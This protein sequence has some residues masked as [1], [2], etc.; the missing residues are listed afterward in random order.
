M[1]CFTEFDELQEALKR[2]RMDEEVMPYYR[3]RLVENEE[4]YSKIQKL[5][6]APEMQNSHRYLY[7]LDVENL[8][9]DEIAK[10]DELFDLGVKK[11]FIDNSFEEELEKEE[12]P[13][14]VV[15]DEEPDVVQIAVKE[16][17][18]PVPCWTILYSA[19][20]NGETKCGE[21][22]SNAI[23][24]SAA[25]A[26]CL[27]KLSRFGYDNV[28]VLAIEAGDPDCAGKDCCNEDD[29]LKGRKHNA[30]IDEE[31]VEENDMLNNRPH[32]AH[33]DE[34]NEDETESDDE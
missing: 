3:G 24:V 34:L 12:N 25:K 32:N 14:A 31:D 20:K 7:D 22:Y 23:S 2:V 8:T 19:T 15:A 17:S 29:L 6:N 4:C 26:D 33:K 1:E 28:S 30:H 9:E 16:P 5:L 10:V 21:C 13:T 11:G 18:A 27:A